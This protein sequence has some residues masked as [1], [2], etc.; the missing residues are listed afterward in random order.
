MWVSRGI[1]DRQ[2]SPFKVW[3][4]KASSWTSL[5][6]CIF[7]LKTKTCFLMMPTAEQKNRHLL[8]CQYVLGSL[9]FQMSNADLQ[10]G[11]GDGCPASSPGGGGSG[12]NSLQ[13][14]L[15]ETE[16]SRKLPGGRFSRGVER[17]CS[18]QRSRIWNWNE[19]NSVAKKCLHFNLA[20]ALKFPRS[21]E[22]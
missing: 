15:T 4:A 1:G 20:A 5:Q 3:R 14:D 9:S 6:L 8:L 13:T 7:F 11:A 19:L 22:R 16:T 2:E 17:P 18:C 12:D 21:F 10:E